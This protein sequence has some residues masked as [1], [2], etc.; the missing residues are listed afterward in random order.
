VD[1]QLRLV[2]LKEPHLEHMRIP[3]NG[4]FTALRRVV[5][6]SLD[7]EVG[8]CLFAN[9]ERLTVLGDG[10]LPPTETGGSKLRSHLQK[11]SNALMELRR[12]GM[13]SGVI[14]VGNIGQL[15]IAFILEGL[16]IHC[17][18]LTSRH[19]SR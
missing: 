8:L 14:D 9:L 2:W 5:G 19:T 12:H 6:P 11:L 3:G 1:A 4:S 15:D 18:S 7:G 17:Y 10:E 13:E 16:L